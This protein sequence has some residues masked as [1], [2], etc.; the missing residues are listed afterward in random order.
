[1]QI[2]RLG[3]WRYICNSLISD[4]S[5]LIHKIKSNHEEATTMSS[6]ESRPP[7][8]V[9]EALERE[10]ERIRCSPVIE[11]ALT[12]LLHFGP[13]HVLEGPC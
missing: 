3:C 11:R 2:T 7:A 4:Q 8:G 1:M 13:M 10:T 12:Q 6:S 5:F 9:L